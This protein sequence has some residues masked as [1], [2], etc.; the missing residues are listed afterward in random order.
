M[1]T[2][3]T[4]NPTPFASDRER[5][6]A[7][8]DWL[9]AHPEEKPDGRNAAW[10]HAVKSEA[11]TLGLLS[12]PAPQVGCNCKPGIDRGIVYGGDREEAF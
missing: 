7:C 4:G 1:K 2:E 5:V 11:V 8:L 6:Q 9:H 12:P 10:I 3:T